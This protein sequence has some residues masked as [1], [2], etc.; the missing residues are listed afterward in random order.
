[1]S[2]HSSL[3]REAFQ[4]LLASAFAIQESGISRESLSVLVD[5]HNSI[6]R[7]EMQFEGILALIADRAR[8]V[9]NATGIAIGILTKDQLV[10][11][12]GSGCAAGYVGRQVTAVLS[13]SDHSGAR[14][15]ILRVEN[16]ETDGRIEAAICREREAKALLMI[17]IYREQVVAGVL[18][19]LFTDPH[20]FDDPE[21]RAY[22]LMAGLVEEARPRDI[23][24][25]KEETPTIQPLAVQRSMV[26]T[27][28]PGQAFCREDKPASNLSGAQ[29][30]DSPT[31][32]TGIRSTVCPPPKDVKTTRWPAK[33]P[34]SY[35]P[36]WAV[37]AAVVVIILGVA[38]W[39]SPHHRAPSTMEGSVRSTAPSQ[40][41]KPSAMVLPPKRASS[42]KAA[43]G[44]RDFTSNARSSFKRVRVGPKEVDYIAEDVTMRRFTTEA[45]GSHAPALNKQFDIGDDVTVLIFTDVL[46][47]SPK[48]R[49]V[50]RR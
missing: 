50:S 8:L 22:R 19:V 36:R 43:A 44:A 38:V 3:D 37:G 12:A 5:I 28:S 26:Q 18:E 23:H 4:T 16:A 40:V 32:A 20:T 46:A 47:V 17:P 24:L 14:K 7:H 2:A 25:G 1:M 31:V 13:L 39:I 15:E 45:A 11:R 6:A 29:L 42:L 34:S 33:R 48:T 49:I 21:M 41:L 10:Y 35:S 9:A 30:C 27:S